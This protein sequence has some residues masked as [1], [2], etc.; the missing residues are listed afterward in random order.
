MQWPAESKDLFRLEPCS[1]AVAYKG[2]MQV[3]S[4]K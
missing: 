1:G 2:L 4:L 3:R